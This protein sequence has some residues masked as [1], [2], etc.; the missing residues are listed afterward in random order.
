M[1]D[2][3]PVTPAPEGTWTQTIAPIVR[4]FEVAAA[5]QCDAVWNPVGAKAC[6]HLF[7]E[8]ARLL[9]NDAPNRIRTLEEAFDAV[10]AKNANAMR[11]GMKAIQ[12]IRHLQAELD[13]RDA[14]VAERDATI[15]DLRAQIAALSS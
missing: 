15:A 5:I 3:A 13:A 2:K 9:D 6:A 14:T 11:I 4:K 7:S 8:M 10:C 12:S 1:T